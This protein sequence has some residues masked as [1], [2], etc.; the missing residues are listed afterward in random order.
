MR[1]HTCVHTHTQ[2][3][4]AHTYTHTTH[5]H[6]HTQYTCTHIHTHMNKMHNIMNSE[7]KWNQKTIPIA[8]I[9]L[10]QILSCQ[11]PKSQK[12]ASTD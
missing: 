11:K 3:T 2:H 12:S 8:I 9:K 1:A 7:Q 4:H 5:M 6:T 10:M